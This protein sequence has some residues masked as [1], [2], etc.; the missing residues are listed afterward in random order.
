M[1]TGK[2][3]NWLS[4]SLALAGAAW[5]FVPMRG[6]AYQIV[7]AG[8]APGQRDVRIYNNFTDAAANDNVAAH[9]NFPG[10]LGA[11]MA[12]WKACVEWGSVLHG[13]GNGDS[14]Q[15]GGLGSGGANFD[16][17]WAGEADGVGST[18]ANIVSELAGSSGSVYAFT[19]LPADNGWRIRFYSVWN[20]A[21]G[22]DV[23]IGA[24][25]IDIQ[26]I[27]THEYGHAL[28]LGHSVSPGSTMLAGVSGNGVSLRTIET[29]DADGVQA[30]YGTISAGKP[31]ITGIA[32]SGSTITITGQNFAATGNEV[33]FTAP[34]TTPE[35]NTA[36]LVVVG[37][38]ASTGGGT[39]ISV[40]T[41]STAGDGDI[42]VKI[43]GTGF[44]T[45]S[46]AWPADVNP[47]PACNTPHNTCVMNPN[48]YSLFGASMAY[49]GTTSYAQ[50][51]LTLMCYDIPPLKGTLFYYGRTAN[52]FFPF[53][54]GTRCVDTPLY[55]LKPATTSDVMGIAIRVID[56]NDMPTGGSMLPGSE[57]H[58]SA[59]FRDPAAGGAAFN[60]ADV[61]SW[62]W[63][64]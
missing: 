59:F 61:L 51:D 34:N 1:Q 15:P 54:N 46:N 60:S 24:G 33:W 57:M 49:A 7:G 30:I 26:G 63:C 53:G 47:G 8:L 25:T 37:A 10:A 2:M 22:P 62:I 6:E 44:D 38:Q 48:S 36:P 19:E 13:N 52:G 27:M 64:P 23:G 31:R 56:L 32:I 35:G 58:A 55:R 29:D 18:D 41:P 3:R 28:G 12:M 16:A 5:V 14:S 17:A 20:W 45:V 40:G 39:Q 42:L 4:S 43:P 21:D 9:T 50:N 11:P